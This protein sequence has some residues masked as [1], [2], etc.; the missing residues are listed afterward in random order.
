MPSF[1]SPW[2]LSTF[3]RLSA[4][5]EVD[6]ITDA[7][8][9]ARLAEAQMDVISDIAGVYPDCLYQAPTAL[10]AG[11]DSK[12][13]TFG[14]DAQG[15]A[16]APY[17]HVGIYT[18]LTHIPDNPMA[19]GL[20]YLNESTQIR[21]PNDR[22]WGGTLYGRWIPTPAD[23]TA[24]VEPA[25]RP[26]PARILIVIKAV[27]NFAAEGG[28]MPSLAADMDD[29]YGREF[30]KWMLTLRTQFRGGGAIGN[31]SLD[32]ALMGGV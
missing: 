8:K 11:A 4:R 23:I 24:A 21:I 26:A 25:L 12:T 17:G 14:T 29:R 2:L 1:D 15:H 10:T 7:S 13:F 16:V 19:D 30:S 31:T 27:R 32:R 3:D 6:E 9:Y 28:Q 22:T 20:D 18:A 5:P